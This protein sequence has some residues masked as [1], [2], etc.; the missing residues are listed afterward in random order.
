[1]EKVE[2]VKVFNSDVV[3]E[4]INKIRLDIKTKR[5]DFIVRF[6]MKYIN[7]ELLFKK[8]KWRFE[9][10]FLYDAY[11]DRIHGDTFELHLHQDWMEFRQL[12]P[13]GLELMIFNYKPIE[14]L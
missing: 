11:A 13:N 5:N 7:H 3:N 14:T 1:M 12:P 10:P 9:D 8:Y 2:I 6:P 4:G